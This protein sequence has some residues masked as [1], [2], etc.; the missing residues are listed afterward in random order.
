[1]AAKM[2]KTHI[3]MKVYKVWLQSFYK[4]QDGRQDGRRTI[5]LSK[6]RHNFCFKY[7]K[8]LILMF[9]HMF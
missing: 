4:I 1:M 5:G 7:N 2:V 8:I 3:I 6:S 9:I